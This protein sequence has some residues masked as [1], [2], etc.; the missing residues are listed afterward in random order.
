MGLALLLGILVIVLGTSIVL[1]ALFDVDVP[2]FRTAVGVA[3]LYLGV[4][5]LAGAWMPVQTSH[6]G[7]EA[8]F[9]VTHF[10]PTDAAGSRKYEIIFGRGVVDL[11]RLPASDRERV[12]QVDVV[13]G[14][15]EIAIDPAIPIEVSGSAAFGEVRMPDRS[16][17]NFGA[18]RYRNA[19]AGGP[20]IELVVNAVFG[21]ARIVERVTQ[22][23]GADAP[24]AV[25]TPSA[26]A[27]RATES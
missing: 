9:A 1:H 3:F 5:V 27:L 19:A 7:H 12:V 13:F 15:A 24:V 4:R 25:E 20:P 2:I 22:P 14:D 6:D 8:I 26:P 11:T 16:A 21:T 10:T 17:A 18:V 23:V